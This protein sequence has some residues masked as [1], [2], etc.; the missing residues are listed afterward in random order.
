[1]REGVQGDSCEKNRFLICS[2]LGYDA[3][4]LP[5]VSGDCLIFPVE[6]RGLT[7]NRSILGYSHGQF[8][9][10]LQL[11]RFSLLNVVGGGLSYILL[12]MC[13]RNL[14]SYCQSG[15]IR[16][17]ARRLC[18]QRFDGNHILIGRTMD[19]FFSHHY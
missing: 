6:M 11:T 4:L 5:L 13:D 10:N 14:H 12:Y 19:W 2:G 18:K 15:I 9:C 17:N 8:V 1:M 7:I 16:V 3:R